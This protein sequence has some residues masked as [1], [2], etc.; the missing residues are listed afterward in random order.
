[1][2]MPV[3]RRSFRAHNAHVSRADNKNETSSH[4]E[5][6]GQSVSQSGG[7][8]SS[9]RL[10]TTRDNRREETH[11]LEKGTRLPD[12]SRLS[13][14]FS[15]EALFDSCRRR[16]PWRVMPKL[17]LP[18]VGRSVGWLAGLAAQWA[19]RTEA[20]GAMIRRPFARSRVRRLPAT[21]RAPLDNN[22]P[23]SGAAPTNSSH[24]YSFQR[25]RRRRTNNGRNKL[26]GERREIGKQTISAGVQSEEPSFCFL[27]PTRT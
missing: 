3:A 7:R 16:R 24:F 11:A 6:D 10:T 25:R 17:R 2:M 18:T 19:A 4:R 5:P 13:Q 14:V 27:I 23:A 21:R 20:A 26:A 9:G 8:H 12:T 15:C 1:M 22:R